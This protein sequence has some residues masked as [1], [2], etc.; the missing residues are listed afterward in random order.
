MALRLP[1][2]FACLWCVYGGV[3]IYTRAQTEREREG[4]CEISHK[5]NLDVAE[6]CLHLKIST[7]PRT[8]I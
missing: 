3:F 8:S 6:N 2:V 1:C 7:I 5:W 4:V